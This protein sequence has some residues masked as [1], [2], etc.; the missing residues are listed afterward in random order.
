MVGGEMIKRKKLEPSKM[1]ALDFLGDHTGMDKYN[2]KYKEKNINDIRHILCMSTNSTAK[3]EISLR[4]YNKQKHKE[5]IELPKVK[6][7]E[8]GEIMS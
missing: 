3:F 7:Q 6:T 1:V 2:Y 4:N 8:Q 5:R